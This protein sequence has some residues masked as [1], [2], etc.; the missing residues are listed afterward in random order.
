MDPSR[1]AALLARADPGVR[2]EVEMLLA[3]TGDSTLTEV[4]IGSRLGPYQLEAP[5][6][7][8]GMGQV[9][10]ALD[11]R[12]GRPVAIKI[13]H[14]RFSA[15]F[16]REA[17]AISA[18]N[19]P[20]ICTLYDIGPDYLVMELVEG[21]TLAARLQKGAIPIGQAMQFGIW[22]AD[23]LSAAHTAGIVHRD[24]KPANIML[25]KTGL[26]VLDFGLAKIDAG[27]TL[28]QANAVMGTPAYMSPE[29]RA[30]IE[31]D[32]RADIYSFGLVLCEMATGK[33]AFPGQLP[34]LEVLPEKLA[35]VI[36]RCLEQDP[37]LRWQSAK[38]VKAELEWAA[39]NP[40][41]AAAGEDSKPR[42]RWIWAIAALAC[43]TLLA[44]GALVLRRS[45]SRELP[46]RLSL[47][48]EGLISTGLPQPS[49]DGRLF[50]FTGIDASGKQGLWVRALDAENSRSLPGTEDALNPFWSADGH[51]IG[52][53]SGGKIKRVDPFNGTTQTV[54]DF[55][56]APGP[57]AAWNAHGDLLLTKPGRYPLWRLQE[58]GGAA[59]PITQFDEGR[60]ENS[61]RWPVFLPDGRHFL[62]VARCVL[63][64]NNGLYLGVLDSA[65]TTRLM[66]VE[67]SVQYV[68]ARN[69]RSAALLYLREGTLF[70]QPFDGERLMGQP[71]PV[72]QNVR[73][74]PDSLFG[75]FRAAADG[76][77]LVLEMASAGASLSWFDRD[78]KSLGSLG[79][80]GY[81]TAPRISPNG[82]RVVFARSDGK[83]GNFDIWYMETARGIAT[84]L[85][86][87]PAN[88]WFP[89]WSPDGRGIAF[90]SDRGGKA[91]NELYEK[92]SLEPGVGET[93]LAGIGREVNPDDWSTDGRWIAAHSYGQLWIVPTSRD[94]KPFPFLESTFTAT[95]ARFSP[96]GKWLA[97]ASN[98]TGR[99]EI[100]VRPFTGGP[101]GPEGKIQISNGGGDFPVWSRDG[102]ELLYL[103]NG[104]DLYS[105]PVRDFGQGA[106][107]IPSRLFSV[108]SGKPAAFSAG[109]FSSPFDVSPDGQRF[110][111]IC[112]TEQKFV[113]LMNWDAAKAH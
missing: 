45:T 99:I 62:F 17:R 88:D 40:R 65:R 50:A 37:E 90:S 76:T 75:S 71:A 68:P 39:R 94:G 9:F 8:G 58:S 15:R 78:G 91:L 24:L 66:H 33:R 22:I 112:A 18:L 109:N 41:V 108:C 49:P 101:A 53:W 52:F 28:T 83:V 27:E 13:S 103:S 74:L 86:L 92:K 10:R 36:E 44:V 48:F 32:A 6:G 4:G 102:K 77:D 107:P 81:Y 23:A 61:H 29:Q 89:I 113:V 79:A 59:K 54:A 51:W 35:H 19:H 67:S 64:D 72:A 46:M 60:G 2:R 82:S 111:V 57:G 34:S 12:L 69:G 14:E 38:D 73:F 63:P 95:H 42:R 26:K 105:V 98:E 20:H 31:C 25:T 96:D 1:R 80:P 106:G 70:E 7:A 85:T 5:L 30:G 55:P 56:V 110:L 93:P 21:E 104:I 11:T 16:E 43:G 100:Y 47:S 84:R 87:S 3:Q 97:Y